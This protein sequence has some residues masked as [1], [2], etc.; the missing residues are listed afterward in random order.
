MSVEIEIK[1][2]LLAAKQINPKLFLKLAQKRFS[3]QDMEHQLRRDKMLLITLSVATICSFLLIIPVTGPFILWYVLAVYRP[4]IYVSKLAKVLHG[5]NSVATFP[6]AECSHLALRGDIEHILQDMWGKDNSKTA[7]T[8][9]QLE[10]TTR[11]WKHLQAKLHDIERKNLGLEEKE[12]LPR[13]SSLKQRLAVETD[14][15]ASSS[16]RSQLQA[17]EGQL[18][19]NANLKTWYNR[20]KNAQD[21]STESLKQLRSSLVLQATTGNMHNTISEVYA[22]LQTLNTGL[23][24]VQQAKEEVLISP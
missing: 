14:S 3:F 16:L 5:K 23:A 15:I 19:A 13:Q 7:D 9:Q 10:Q 18:K 8:L 6:D 12:L 21:E 24:S 1:A 20:L 22:A 4:K 11:Q 17:V 2:V